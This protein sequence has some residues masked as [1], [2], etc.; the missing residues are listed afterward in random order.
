MNTS[1]E[2][3]LHQILQ[4]FTRRWKYLLMLSLVFTLGA[5]IKHKYFPS[6]PGTGKLII[7]DVRNSQLQSIIGH[8]AG[9]GAEIATPELKGD[10]LVARAE[11][12]LD[13]HEFYVAVTNR[14]LDIKHDVKNPA[15]ESFFSSF[16]KDENDP[17][18]VHEVANKISNM[19]TFNSSKADVLSI[20]AKSN[21]KE[22]TVMLV[23]E[24]L[25]EAQENLTERELADLNRAENYF[26]LEIEN[27][28]SRLDLIENS[29][30][31]KMQKNQI[32]SVDSEKGESARY[33]GELKKTIND[34]KI[35]ISNNE[36]RI[37]ELKDKMR[38][39]QVNDT[40]ISKFN[41]SSQIKML[42]DQNRDLGLEL[43]TSQDYLKSFETQ[44]N[45]LVPFQ[46]EIEKMNA[47]HDFEYK[48]YA[49]LND[50]L[51][52]IGLQKTYAKNKV[53]ILER[54]RLSRVRSSPPLLIM[55]L[56][57]LTLSQ[58]FGIFSIY[59]YELFKPTTAIRPY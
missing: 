50:S 56:I 55:I 34:T 48:M 38:S 26:N 5:L 28:K 36:G 58:V 3:S 20:D 17:E 19:I 4:I 51:A 52:R 49:S 42:E 7:K 53:E 43:K 46:Y 47:S 25:R 24:T 27:V 22:F 11:A 32:F 54:E 15:L 14:L 2:I 37:R 6:Y 21:N 57:A 31:K 12:L 18:F 1:D 16:N 41:E 30:V 35:A 23:N 9:V 59:V 44:K 39:S 45:G 33:M 40:V 29:T 13:I 8:V 10:D